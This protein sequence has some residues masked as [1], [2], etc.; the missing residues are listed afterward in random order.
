MQTSCDK[1]K[2]Y[3]GFGNLAQIAAIGHNIGSDSDSRI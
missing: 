1:L 3:D 2:L